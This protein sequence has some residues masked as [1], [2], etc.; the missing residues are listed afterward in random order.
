M[1]ACNRGDSQRGKEK[2]VPLCHSREQG[3]GP[4]Y[5]MNRSWWEKN[6]KHPAH[7]CCFG[8]EDLR[9]V[10]GAVGTFR[11]GRRGV[12]PGETSSL[13]PCFTRCFAFCLETSEVS[14]DLSKDSPAQGRVAR[15]A[16][17]KPQGSQGNGATTT[18]WVQET[19]RK[20]TR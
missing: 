6:Q 9:D 14:R 11:G 7:R 17:L 20:E 19:Q 8:K 13:A 16:G 5:P 2:P 3:V 4:G 15:P 12:S 18:N 10:P 1:L